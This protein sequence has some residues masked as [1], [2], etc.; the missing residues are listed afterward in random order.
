MLN[1]VDPRTKH[2]LNCVDLVSYTRVSSINWDQKRLQRVFA[3]DDRFKHVTPR[4]LSQHL[5]SHI[6]GYVM[7]DA[8][9]DVKDDTGMSAKDLSH[10]RLN[11]DHPVTQAFLDSLYRHVG[12]DIIHTLNK[13][14]DPNTKLSNTLNRVCNIM[15]KHFNIPDEFITTKQNTV[16]I[17]RK[18]D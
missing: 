6:R 8:L 7:C 9:S 11:P 2:L 17:K 1:R 15:F 10:H 13:K 16:Q 5:N 18:K 12:K 14:N 4:Q 3:M